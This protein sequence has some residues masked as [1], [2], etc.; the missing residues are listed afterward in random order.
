MVVC[1]Y[2]LGNGPVKIYFVFFRKQFHHFATFPATAVTLQDFT[3]LQLTGSYNLSENIRIFGRIDNLLD[4]EYEET[5]GF[6]TPE[7]SAF[8]GTEIEF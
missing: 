4:K 2:R 6:A 1:S 8:I 5:L 7:L 3:L